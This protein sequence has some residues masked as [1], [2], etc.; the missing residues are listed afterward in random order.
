M[1]KIALIGNP[2]SHSLSPQLFHLAYSTEKKVKDEDCSK[3]GE[4]KSS[5]IVNI[6]GEEYLYEIVESAKIE[7]AISLLKRGKYIGANVTA[8]YKEQIMSYVTH[9]DTISQTIGAA[10]L[11]LFKGKEIHSYNTDYQVALK[12]AQKFISQEKRKVSFAVVGCGGVGKSSILACCDAIKNY[13]HNKKKSEEQFEKI[14][15]ANRTSSIAIDY[16]DKLSANRRGI[17]SVPLNEFA[18]IFTQYPIGDKIVFYTLPVDEGI[19]KYIAKNAKKEI[20]IIEPNYLNPA[21]FAPNPNINYI[22]GIEWLIEQAEYGFEIFTGKKPNRERMNSIV[23]LV[24][25]G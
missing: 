12:F 18:Q 21:H 1:K 19:V 17:I 16:A 10:N 2:V 13:I 25:K 11:I 8:P 9:P 15:I 6:E 7:K 22:G 23:D 14:I 3:K 24:I 5:D 4:R 20:T